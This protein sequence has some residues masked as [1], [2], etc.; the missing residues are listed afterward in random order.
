MHLI[1]GGYYVLL[2]QHIKGRM[3]PINGFLE[4]LLNNEYPDT[5]YGM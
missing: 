5:N 1:E 4:N 3:Y 2:L